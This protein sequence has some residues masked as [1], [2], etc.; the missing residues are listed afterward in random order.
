MDTKKSL[1]MLSAYSLMAMVGGSP[2]FYRTHRKVYGKRPDPP[3]VKEYYLRKAAE[4]R[5]R[6]IER[7]MK[8][9]LGLRDPGTR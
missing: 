6:K 3:E 2:K 4:K 1:A 9:H 5:R 7:M 8:S